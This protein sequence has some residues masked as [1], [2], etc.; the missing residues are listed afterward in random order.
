MDGRTDLPTDTARCRVA[1]PRLKTGKPRGR[2]RK[3]EDPELEKKRETDRRHYRRKKGQNEEEEENE[4][5]DQGESGASSKD[6]T[7]ED[8]NPGVRIGA[9]RPRSV[10]EDEA[11]RKR[12]E[13]NKRYYESR[14]N[15]PLKVKLPLVSNTF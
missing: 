3:T 9:G 10:T 5:F 13:W 7:T 2:P 14:K 6:G 8:D 11:A 12:Q 1:C 15:R 4:Q